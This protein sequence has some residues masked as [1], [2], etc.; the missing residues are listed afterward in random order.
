MRFLRLL[1]PALSTLVAAPALA[2]PAPTVE[3]RRCSLERGTNATVPRLDDDV[4]T[5]GDVRVPAPKGSYLLGESAGEYVVVGNRAIVRVAKDGSTEEVT[6]TAADAQPMLSRDGEHVILVRTSGNGRSRIRVLDAQT[7]DLVARRVFS[8][9]ARVLDATEG[10]LVLTASK[11][12]RTQWWN[13][14]SDATAPIA[15]RL[16]GRVDILADRVATFTD[17]PYNGGCTVVTSLRRPA[18]VLWRSC[19]EAVAAFS[20]NGARMATMYILTD[21][22]GPG[23]VHA[24]RTNGGAR[25]A[26]YTA[27]WFG[28]IEWETNRA[29][30]LD[31]NTKRRA[32]DVRCVAGDCE[33]ASALRRP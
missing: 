12:A 8:A 23:A 33:R 21:G 7:G 19:T 29:L 6:R 3:I 17:D 4:I 16:G 24:R 26:S 25:I 13:F 10:R 22:L 14:L 5:D 15:S 28:S 11:P 27:R 9:Y 30:L 18:R 2:A 20:P 31:A 1:L 32:A